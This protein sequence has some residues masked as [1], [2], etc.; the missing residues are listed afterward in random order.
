[1]QAMN[2]ATPSR[3]PHARATLA[4]TC[5]A[6]QLAMRGL[7]LA[8]LCRTP[9]D[10]C[11]ATSQVARCLKAIGDHA[12]AEKFL[13][14][15]LGWTV[16]MH[17]IDARVDLLCELAEVSCSLAETCD[18]EDDRTCHAALER[19]RDHAFEAARWATHA[20][21]PHW[22]VKVLLRA[23][24]VLNRCGDHVDAASMQDRAIVLI[25]LLPVADLQGE[26]AG[27]GPRLQGS[28]WLM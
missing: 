11:Q 27:E 20:A 16:Q 19:A 1:M 10:M 21:D 18:V 7:D 13:R 24:D 6:L 5:H 2:L 17:G 12:S 25:G 14:Q 15:A 9:L 8:E 23:S 4:V 3:D 22:Q 28:H 26:T